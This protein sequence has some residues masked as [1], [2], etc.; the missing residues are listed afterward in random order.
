MNCLPALTPQV[1]RLE[2]VFMETA[3]PFLFS[4]LC[5][6]HLQSLTLSWPSELL[7]FRITQATHWSF[8]ARPKGRGSPTIL[9][10]FYHDNVTLGNI[11][12][13][14]G[15]GLSFNLSLTH[16][17]REYSCGADKGTRTQC[18]EAE[19]LFATGWLFLGHEPQATDPTCNFYPRGPKRLSDLRACGSTSDRLPRQGVSQDKISQYSDSTL[20]SQKAL[21]SMVPASFGLS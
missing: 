1:D 18:N 9:Y 19:T 16:R 17:I 2:G 20:S 12:A 13:H 4:L 10:Q 8:T 5:L 14:F 7:G 11:S 3:R 15:E 21:G 6:C